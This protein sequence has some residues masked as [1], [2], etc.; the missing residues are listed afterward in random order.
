MGGGACREDAPAPAPAPALPLAVHRPRVKAFK[1]RGA[2]TSEILTQW[3]GVPTFKGENLQVPGS[4]SAPDPDT[5]GP[6]TTWRDVAGSCLTP[7]HS[8]L[9]VQALNPLWTWAWVS[10]L[11]AHPWRPT[12]SRCLDET[13]PGPG[14]VSLQL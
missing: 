1:T 6:P 9:G 11:T 8:A 14:T 4:P 12:D 13:W 10:L 7:S 5:V 2:R 3:A